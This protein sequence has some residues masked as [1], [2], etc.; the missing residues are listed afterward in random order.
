MSSGARKAKGS[1]ARKAKGGRFGPGER[2]LTPYLNSV[3]TARSF[4]ME[5]L[6]CSAAM[7]QTT[8]SI[9]AAEFAAFDL[10]LLVDGQE[11]SGT[12]A[13]RLLT[14]QER[15]PEAAFLAI[16]I[17][18]MIPSF[19]GIRS[20][21][22]HFKLSQNQFDKV[23]ALI[24]CAP[25]DPEYIALLPIDIFK[26]LFSDGKGGRNRIA[27][28]TSTSHSHYSQSMSALWRLHPPPA[29]PTQLYPFMLPLASLGEAL[30]E[31][32]AAAS[33]EGPSSW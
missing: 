3:Q 13:D 32:R 23:H 1:G 31:F 11:T 8:F 29:F 27:S 5:A 15:T 30:R 14:L 18:C 4:L 9:R 21:Y 7:A 10:L 28:E 24:L 17:K 25:K 16:D 22:W 12:A 26:R 19:D 33:R 20:I 6:V 2:T